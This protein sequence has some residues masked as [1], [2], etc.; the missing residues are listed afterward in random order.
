MKLNF[1]KVYPLIVLALNE[2]IGKGDITTDICIPKHQ[3]STATITAKQPGIICGLELIEFIFIIVNPKIKITYFKKDGQQV[4]KGDKIVTIKGNTK[5]ILSTERIILNF[6]QQLSGVATISNQYVTKIKQHNTKILDT[7]K[8]LPGMRYLQKYAVICGGAQNHRKGLYD[9]ILIKDNHIKSAGSITK[10][11]NL[12]TNQKTN[13]QNK[14][15]NEKSKYKNISDIKIEVE[16]STLKQV[17]E[18]L[19]TNCNWIMLDNMPLTEMKTALKLINKQKI[20]EASGGITLTNLSN[21]AKLG[22]DYISTG[23]ITHSYKALDLSMN[24]VD[25]NNDDN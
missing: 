15:K 1:D 16:C 24:I 12:C 11:V 14:K 4:K 6:L 22:V 18:A 2:D 7:R 10:A 13:Y 21:I 25:N 19:Q 8:T 3:T 5:S 17:K 20:V 23:A 9:M